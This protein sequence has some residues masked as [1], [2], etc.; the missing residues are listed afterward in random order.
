MLTAEGVIADQPVVQYPGEVPALL[1][2]AAE[3]ASSKGLSVIALAKKLA[4]KPARVRKMLGQD[5]TRAMLHLVR[6][7]DS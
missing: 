6:S 3:L 1:H 5:D 4:W 2:D 7:N